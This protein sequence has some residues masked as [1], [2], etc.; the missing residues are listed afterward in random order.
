MLLPLIVAMGPVGCLR[1]DTLPIASLSFFGND[2][3]RSLPIPAYC[4]VCVVLFAPF[5]IAPD[6]LSFELVANSQPGC[7]LSVNNSSDV[8]IAFKVPV[9]FCLFEP[10][11]WDFVVALVILVL[12]VGEL[13]TCRDMY[14]DASLQ[15]L[16]QTTLYCCTSMFLAWG[17]E[18]LVPCVHKKG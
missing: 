11:S 7:V 14:A 8:T 5:Q 3:L 9:F 10:K 15:R 4:H 1:N 13:C 18:N 6:T 16:L 17:M 2:L 12:H